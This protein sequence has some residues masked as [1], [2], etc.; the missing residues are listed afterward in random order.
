MKYI[1]VSGNMNSGMHLSQEVMMKYFPNYLI[2]IGEAVVGKKNWSL[3]N[4]AKFSN[5]AIRKKEEFDLTHPNHKLYF[6]SAGFQIIV[7]D[8]PKGRIDEWTSAYHWFL[9]RY[10]SS[11]DYIF[12]LDIN[13]PGKLSGDEIYNYNIESTKRTL[14]EI[15]IDP[16]LRD[17]VIYVYQTRNPFVY[18]EWIKIEDELDTINQFNRFSLGGLVGFK[19]KAKAK[20]SPFVPS[21]MDF[22]TLATARRKGG[23]DSVGQMHFLG[24]STL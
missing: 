23:I 10:S 4:L 12:S 21:M 11:I 9:K 15:D 20:F 17:K 18:Q 5:Q 14:A 6:D 13:I 22:L 1:S 7:G 2:S 19:S 3:K 8:I 24:Q 16:T